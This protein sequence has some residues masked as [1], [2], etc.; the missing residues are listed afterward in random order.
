MNYDIPLHVTSDDDKQKVYTT[1][2]ALG[3]VGAICPWNFPL[4]LAMNKIGPAILT[5]N[6][7]IVKPSYAS[8]STIVIAPVDC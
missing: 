1:Y 5:G 2:Q 6:T 8:I 7:I 3:I 4:I